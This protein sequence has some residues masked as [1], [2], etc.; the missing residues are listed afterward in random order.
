MLRVLLL[1]S[2]A[3][4]ALAALTLASPAFAQAAKDAPGARDAP[5][6][7]DP[8]HSEADKEI[9]VSAPFSQDADSRLSGTTILTGAALTRDIRPTIGETLAHQPGVSSTA[10]GPNAS[11][12]VLRGFQGERVR[13]LTDGIGSID[14]SNT[15]VDHA[16]IINPL[17]ADRIEVLRGPAALLFGSSAI[18][19]VVNVLSSRIPRKVPNEAVHI[20]ALGSYGSA[21]DE[22]SGTGTIDVPLSS[23][24]VVHFDGSYTKTG[25]LT[26]GGYLLSAPLRAQALASA[27]P[28]IRELASLKGRLPNSAAETWEVAGAAALITDDGTLGFSVSHYDSLYGVPLRFSL[29]PGVAAE[30]VRLDV[31]Q[32]REDLR[33]EVNT[34]DGFLAKVKFRA[35][36]ASYKHSE[37]DDTG[38]IGT[39]FLNDSF[40]ARLELVQQEQ[41]GWKGASGAQMSI[42]DFNV[43]GAEA[44]V[45]RN[46]TSQLGIFTLQELK[47]GGIKLEGGARFEHTGL[48]ADASAAIGNPEY[49]VRFNA[50][51]GSLG[52]SY[53]VAPGIRFGLNAAH[54]ERAPAA[55]EL[56]A[57]GPHAGT[58]AFEIGDPA[59]KKEISDGVEVSLHGK[60]KGFSFGASLYYTKF[61]NYIYEAQTGAVRNNLPVFQFYQASARYY[62]F[63]V[64]GS[65]QVATI[66]TF[67][68]VADALADMVR[69]RITSVGPVPRIP[70]LRV[71]GGLEAQSDVIQLRVEA[72]WAD[73]QTRVTAFETPTKGYTLVNASLSFK[74]FGTDNGMSIVVSANNIFNV[75][76]RR[77]ASFLKDFAPLA[78]RDLRVSARIAF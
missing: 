66:G 42:R 8:Y 26:T 23:K 21:S 64:E 5:V 35:G 24:F 63:E 55:E 46:T 54:T 61:K 37:I 78:G 1:S 43:I 19:G 59:F 12:P 76:A 77:H 39:T 49:A 2:A 56:F 16:V 4:L 22:R 72:E 73:R 10:F 32:T 18:G 40:E 31:Q 53:E 50:Y 9:V 27:D 33:A 6:K 67:K 71:L 69:A 7:D 60:G 52:A 74:P 25:D 70:P 58:Q 65:A 41:N 36:H 45:P 75:E 13:V 3:S 38:A 44:F 34:G 62:G 68:I 11:R 57:N 47:A 30:Q 51:S 48:H 17:T 14:V 15:S 20:D 29:E 28:A